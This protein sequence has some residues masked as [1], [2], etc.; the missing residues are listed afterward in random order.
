MKFSKKGHS[1]FWLEREVIIFS[2]WSDEATKLVLPILHIAFWSYGLSNI[3]LFQL[4]RYCYYP[5]Q[6]ISI[7][8]FIRNELIIYS[9]KSRVQY[10]SNKHRDE[11][12][13]TV[14]PPGLCDPPCCL[15]ARGNTFW[16]NTVC[17][18]YSVLATGIIT[19]ARSFSAATFM[20]TCGQ[21]KSNHSGFT[22]TT[23]GNWTHNFLT[24]KGSVTDYNTW[25]FLIRT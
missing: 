25:L 10:R 15:V 19:D 18:Q 24:S 17:T 9:F 21:V 13:S 16:S 5:I 3:I 6:I 22:A 20:N 4:A 7:L 2:K 1:L 11:A 23:C 12:K 14:Y 8:F